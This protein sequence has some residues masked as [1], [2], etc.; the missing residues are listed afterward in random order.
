MATS[1]LSKRSSRTFERAGVERIVIGGDVLPGPMPRECLDLLYALDIPTDFII[2]NGDRE[3]A[4]A[5][6]GTVSSVI[7]E[8]FREALRWN[9]SQL[10]PRRSGG[11]RLHGR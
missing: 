10:R 3:T 11:D 6:R 9:A 4:G 5:A 8:F 7:P 2:G 1:R